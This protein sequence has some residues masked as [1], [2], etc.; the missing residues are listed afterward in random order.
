MLPLKNLVA[1]Q[2]IIDGKTKLQNLVALFNQRVKEAEKAIQNTKIVHAEF[3]KPDWYLELEQKA[4]HL[5][6]LQLSKM[7]VLNGVEVSL[8]KLHVEKKLTV[9]EAKQAVLA[10][11][12]G[13]QGCCTPSIESFEGDA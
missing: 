13:S 2:V 4:S 7:Q 12:F 5:Q 6:D 9:A 11:S 8:E 1:T 10:S 3:Q